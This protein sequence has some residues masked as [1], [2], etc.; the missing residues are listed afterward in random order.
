[1]FAEID[2]SCRSLYSREEVNEFGWWS[3]PSPYSQVNLVVATPID[4]TI[5]LLIRSVWGS[6]LKGLS[7]IKVLNVMSSDMSMFKLVFIIF[8]VK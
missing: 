3:R 6:Y 4:D 8:V 5:F 1:V 7:K 2:A